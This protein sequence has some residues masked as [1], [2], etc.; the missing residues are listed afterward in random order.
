VLCVQQ[1]GYVWRVG[2]AAYR[3]RSHPRTGLGLGNVWWALGCRC[4][5][6][7]C[8]CGELVIDTYDGVRKGCTVRD[9]HKVLAILQRH[10]PDAAPYGHMVGDSI[11]ELEEPDSSPLVPL[12]RG[13]D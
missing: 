3:S 7:C 13:V 6:C 10:A 5:M 12:V 9:L 1:L 2:A 4:F 11:D 8:P